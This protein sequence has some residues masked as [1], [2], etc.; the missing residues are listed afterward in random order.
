[1]SQYS[2]LA[3]RLGNEIIT[4]DKVVKAAQSQAQ[5]A[6][7]M[8]DT[9]FYQAAALSLQN[10]YMGAERIF[11]EIA[12]QIDQSLPS[13]ANS[14]QQLLQRMSLDIP[15]TRPPLLSP[16]TLEQLNDYRSFC[17]VVM[18]RYGFEFRL[19]RVQALVKQ[20][21]ICHQQLTQDV[22]NFCEFLLA[23]DRSI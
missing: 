23:L 2:V 14:H 21:P 22:E 7:A 13:G 12:K 11:E 4:L 16:E 3:A 5:K 1:M 17:H 20:L 8:G 19:D 18:H 6:Q 15:Q 9:D 10:Y